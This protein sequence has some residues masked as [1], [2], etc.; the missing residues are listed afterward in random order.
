MALNKDVK[1]YKSFWPFRIDQNISK[2]IKNYDKEV[3]RVNL[4][5]VHN[6]KYVACFLIDLLKK[7]KNYG[8]YF[9]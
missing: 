7:S 8:I 2:L 5:T 3:F 4:N 6:W 1:A 9:Y